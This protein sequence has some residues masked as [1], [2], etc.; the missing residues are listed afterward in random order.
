MDAP[1]GHFTARACWI[2]TRHPHKADKTS[3]VRRPKYFPDLLPR[4]RLTLVTENDR[5]LWVEGILAPDQLASRSNTYTDMN[6]LNHTHSGLYLALLGTMTFLSLPARADDTK[7][8]VVEGGTGTSLILKGSA[9]G[10]IALK[11]GTIAWGKASTDAVSFEVEQTLSGSDVLNY[12][13]GLT[14][15][16][17]DIKPE[18]IATLPLP[19][20][21][22]SIG[23]AIS[24]EWQPAPTWQAAA[25]LSSTWS[26]SANHGDSGSHLSS[27][28]QS[29]GLIG[30]VNHPFN[31]NF[32]TSFGFAYNSKGEGLLRFWPILGVDWK[33]S[34]VWAIRVGFPSTGIR[35]RLSKQWTIG[36]VA[37]GIG[38]SYYV[39]KDPLPNH[40]GKPSLDHSRLE[41]YD[42]RAGL[43]VECSFKPGMTACITLGTVLVEDCIYRKPTFKILSDTNAA[44]GSIALGYRF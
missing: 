24:T 27:A 41:F 22:D 16:H 19:A 36:L 17:I 26:Y 44:Y 29:F 20:Q 40:A 28:G 43:A 11:S 4:G 23:I 42:L 39:A 6:P 2:F 8:S 25:I 37:E 7:V 3:V 34:D 9:A 18:Q 10:D 13:A 33:L 12:S 1:R 5:L 15:E 31:D 14:Y 35:Y 21:L 32:S 30:V 38:G